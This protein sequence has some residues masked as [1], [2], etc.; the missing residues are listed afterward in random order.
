MVTIVRL[1][2]KETQQHRE[3]VPECFLSAVGAASDFVSEEDSLTNCLSTLGVLW[4]SPFRTTCDRR[5]SRGSR[6]PV[7]DFAFSL[8]DVDDPSSFW[9]FST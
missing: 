9:N 7:D 2:E 6:D 8:G 3:R 1:T 4:T 5:G